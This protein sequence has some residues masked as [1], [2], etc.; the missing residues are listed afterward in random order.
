MNNTKQKIPTQN[1]IRESFNN[2]PHITPA[3]AALKMGVSIK[4]IKRY[5]KAGKFKKGLR[6]PSPF[7]IDHASLMRFFRY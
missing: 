4:T 1:T 5:L 7:I 3:E 6:S 2:E